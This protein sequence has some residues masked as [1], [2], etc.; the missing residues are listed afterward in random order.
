MFRI[1]LYTPTRE[2]ITP[3]VRVLTQCGMSCSLCTEEN[4]FLYLVR[5]D[6]P[7]VAICSVPDHQ[8]STRLHQKVKQ[9]TPQLPFF[10]VTRSQSGMA[11]VLALAEG[12]DRYY[13]EPFSYG[14]MIA[15]IGSVAYTAPVPEW[16]V[17]RFSINLAAQTVR[18][19]NT[20]L[21][22]TK[23]QFALLVVLLRNANQPV[24]RTRIWEAIWGMEEYPRV[25]T[26]DALVSRL[27]RALPLSV[28]RAI[29]P[30][31]G[32]GYRLILNE[33]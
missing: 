33:L 1:L 30:V 8:E 5:Q 31:Y 7:D 2:H 3:L 22:L 14:R 29:R 28:R 9:V 27:R 21:T 13:I 24:S 19:N 18:Y 15:D 32:I 26:I 6:Q 20:L 12:V 4:R 17:G 11:R 25:N 10:V 23:R 16:Q